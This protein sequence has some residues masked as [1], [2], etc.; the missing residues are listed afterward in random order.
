MWR[1]PGWEIA[2]HT[3]SYIKIL[4]SM[5]Y[6]PV[7]SE[8]MTQGTHLYRCKTNVQRE[9]ASFETFCQFFDDE[10]EPAGQ[11][12]YEPN[13][14]VSVLNTP[15]SVHSSPHGAGPVRR[16]IFMEIDTDYAPP[17]AQKGRS[18]DVSSIQI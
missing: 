12:P 13:T 16:Y 3:H 2:R 10:V 11:L 7:S 4:F 5:I 18:I 15:K 6:F 14:M 17:Q 1:P 8:T 9:F